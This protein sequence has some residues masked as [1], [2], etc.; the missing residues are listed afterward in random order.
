[1]KKSILLMLPF[2]LGLA[3]CSGGSPL[4]KGNIITP[5]FMERNFRTNAPEVTEVK[6][7]FESIVEV[8]SYSIEGYFDS[9]ETYDWVIFSDEAGDMA[10]FSQSQGKFITPFV[11]LEEAYID[12]VDVGSGVDVPFA[13]LGVFDD[14]TEETWT[15]TVY[16]ELGNQPFT[17]LSLEAGDYVY[18]NGRALEAYERKD[19][20]WFVAFMTGYTFEGQYA[21]YN[22][23]GTISRK[24]AYSEWIE[25]EGS[26][27]SL[28][29]T[30]RMTEY[31][32]PEL[33]EVMSYSPFGVRLSFYNLEESKFVSSFEVP[34]A[35]YGYVAG[36]FFVF[37]ELNLVEERATEYDVYYAGDKYN[38]TTGKIN[39]TNGNKETLDTNVLFALATD[40]PMEVRDEKGIFKYAYMGDV[41]V[42]RDDKTLENTQFGFILDENVNIA[43]D[44]TGI[45]FQDL[46]RLDNDHYFDAYTY[47]MYD[48]KLNEIAYLP[49]VVD[50]YDG[51]L[52]FENVEGYYGLYSFDGKVILPA[53]YSALF[54]VAEHMFYA[55]DVEGI[56]F[57]KLENGALSEAAKYAGDEYFFYN[58]YGDPF[59]IGAILVHYVD[60]TPEPFYVDLRTGAE[61]EPFE[62]AA[63]DTF[64]GN[65]GYVYA[66]AGSVQLMSLAV[67]RADGSIY[68][69]Q[70]TER[71]TYAYPTFAE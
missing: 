64:L 48:G 36:D 26:A 57:F 8:G 13:E 60:G 46:E 25:Q 41:R 70:Y 1:M 65:L 31:G 53:K 12:S 32:H 40:A 66:L 17:A 67:Q 28:G 56:H 22:L 47:I 71:V 23:D 39:Y 9:S 59:Y 38:V 3:A 4:D 33:A 5:K 49:N 54:E 44:V 10:V 68:L 50:I 16:D 29:Y 45:Y 61:F 62:P 63:D 2:A 6:Y 58:Y 21:V 11:T 27:A 19:N 30:Q 35:A 42:I 37:Q 55:E 15:W 52:R 69:V 24:G 43:A 7:D 51:A 18:V 14:E 34:T 20:E